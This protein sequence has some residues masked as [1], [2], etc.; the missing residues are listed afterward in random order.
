MD[1]ERNGHPNFIS[2]LLFLWIA[3]LIYRG[4]RAALRQTDA[5]PFAS[6]LA[7]GSGERGPAFLEQYAQVRLSRTKWRTLHTLQRMLGRKYLFAAAGKP[8]WLASALAQVFCVRALVSYVS[9]ENAGSSERWKYLPLCFV[10]FLAALGMSLSQH[11]VFFYSVWCGTLAKSAL[12]SAMYRKASRLS[13]YDARGL[14]IL[15]TVDSQRVA[16]CAMYFHFVWFSIVELT[17]TC[18]LLFW[19]LGPAAAFGVLF[20]LA[21]VP[22]QIYMSKAIAKAR[23]NVAQYADERVGEC[24]E[25]LAG[26]RIVK[27]SCLEPL[28]ASKIQD[29]RRNEVKA[30]RRATALKAI[31]S[32]VFFTIPAFVMLSS[33]C[34]YVFVFNRKLTPTVAFSAVGFFNVLARVLNMVPYGLIAI[35]EVLPSL[36]RLDNYFDLDELSEL[37]ADCSVEEHPDDDV[38][39]SIPISASSGNPNEIAPGEEVSKMP[40]LV[41]LENC[42]FS[43]NS[44]DSQFESVSDKVPAIDH[45]ESPIIASGSIRRAAVQS[46]VSKSPYIESFLCNI[47]LQVR[48]TELVACIG[49]VGSG[50]SSLLLSVLKEMPRQRGKCAVYGRVAYCAQNPW[51]LNATLRH[52]IVMFGRQEPVDEQKYEKALY[53]CCLIPDLKLLPSGDNTEIGER[54]VTLSGGQKARVALARAVY[55]DS[56][57]YL[58]DDPLSAVDAA[59]ATQLRHRVFGTNG[60][61]SDKAVLLVTH[62]VSILPIADRVIVMESGQIKFDATFSSLQQMGIKFEGLNEDEADKLEIQ[63]NNSLSEDWWDRD[64]YEEGVRDIEIARKSKEQGITTV[65]EDKRIGKVEWFVY[66]AYLKAAG[67]MWPV[68]LIAA[69]FLLSQAGRTGSDIWVGVWSADKISDRGDSF[70]ALVC[71]C[72]I[73][74]AILFGVVRA[75]LFSDKSTRASRKWLVVVKLY[76]HIDSLAM[77][78]PYRSEYFELPGLTSIAKL[79]ILV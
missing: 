32:A 54:G 64:R 33:F 31:N 39:G 49:P 66:L 3:P 13:A 77:K 58:L 73:S 45:R 30:L 48:Q 15:H 47:S 35:S 4:R 79:S 10:L 72:L 75:I 14:G 7:D 23:T 18:A 78:S 16:E 74:S 28:W 46:G 25:L 37:K 19:V 68:L 42:F 26:I 27:L 43:W 50:K 20:M 38:T 53:A 59:I 62:Q 60:V 22:I 34:A 63:N 2:R 17:A 76:A 8:F 11:A 71:L 29:I 69:G 36:A 51:I 55:A 6:I 65:V 41:V 40:R 9:S 57:V 56:D 24:A 70:Y 44:K 67:G 61:L 12:I 21:T 52:N 5:P 1:K